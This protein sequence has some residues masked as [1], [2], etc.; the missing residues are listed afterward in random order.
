MK[1]KTT[2]KN[3]ILNIKPQRNLQ[4][5]AKEKKD[6]CV[7]RARYGK[8]EHMPTKSKQMVLEI[9]LKSLILG[10]PWEREVYP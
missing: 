9:F 10:D 1:M 8:W 7:S 6:V 3:F 2:S 4:S 5:V